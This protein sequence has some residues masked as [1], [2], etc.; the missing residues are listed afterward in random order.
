[1]CKPR[2]ADHSYELTAG[3]IQGFEALGIDVE[4]ARAARRRFAF[5]CLDWSERRP[6][7]A[8]ALGA[9]L[10]H[11]ALKRKW[12]MQELDSRALSVTRLGRNEMHD[13]FGL[14]MDGT[15]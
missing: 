3:G 11:T 2:R 5:A 15:G 14:E 13:R 8:G 10:L 12:V 4:G 1:L 6:H 7:L 9:A